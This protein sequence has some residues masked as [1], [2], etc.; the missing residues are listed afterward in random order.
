[1]VFPPVCILG[2]RSEKPLLK[3]PMVYKNEMGERGKKG[4]REREG[5]PV[6]MEKK[7]CFF[8]FY[9]FFPYLFLYSPFFSCYLPEVFAKTHGR[10]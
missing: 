8:F 5:S 6:Y 4:K 9:L 3:F 7:P 1:M 2:L 10:S